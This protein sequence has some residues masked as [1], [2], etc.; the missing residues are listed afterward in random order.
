MR[1]LVVIM[2]AAVTAGSTGCTT[3]IK[4]TYYGVTGAQGKFYELKLV[5]P[6]VLVTYKS[7]RVEPFTNALGEHVPQ[8]V[9]AEVN[10][11]TPKMLTESRLFYPEGKR[12]LIKGQI[13]HFTG[14]SGLKG[15]AGSFIGGSEDCVCRVQ[16]LDA[17][18]GDEIGEAIC[19]GIVKSAVR[20]G[21]GELG[22][23]VGKSVS[24]WVEKRLP[25]EVSEARKEELKSKE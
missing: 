18:S 25:K 22:A 2:L 1:S 9:I 19:W 5:D 10:D 24:S 3:A 12:L 23:G 7:C 8:D 17:K 14:K 13:V 21:S 6:N 16:L 20:R 4:Q 15:S 11:Q